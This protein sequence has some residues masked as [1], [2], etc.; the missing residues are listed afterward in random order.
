[1]DEDMTIV[2]GVDGSPASMGA[3]R[4]A[5]ERAKP[6]ATIRAVHVWGQ[7]T[8]SALPGPLGTTSLPLDALEENARLLLD[9][10]VGAVVPDPAASSIEP[11]LR[12]G[13]AAG[14]LLEEAA[15]ADLLVVGTR[16]VGGFR[17]LLMGSVADQVVKHA[18]CPVVI[19]PAPDEGEQ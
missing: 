1:M 12:E 11:V 3:L 2:V 9:A 19:V 18:P 4:W 16:G 10:A 14:T 5:V 6:G 13:S 7:P 15:D 8:L 17:G